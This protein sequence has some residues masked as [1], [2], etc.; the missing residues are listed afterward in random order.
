LSETD[1]DDVVSVDEIEGHYSDNENTE[2]EFDF[3]NLREKNDL[4]IELGSESISPNVKKQVA[5]LEALVDVLQTENRRLRSDRGHTQKT[6]YQKTALSLA[7]VG[8]VAV[9][10]GIVFPDV[11]S[12]LFATGTIGVIG[13]VMTWHLRPAKTVPIELCEGIYQSASMTLTDIRTDLGLEAVAMY[14]SFGNR[15]RGVIP[16]NRDSTVPDDLAHA[17]PTDHKGSKY[18]TFTPSGLSLVHEIEKIRITDKPQDFVTTVEAVAEGIVEHLEVADKV[19]IS[20]ESENSDLRISV[21]DPAFGPLTDIDHPVVSTL[22][23]AAVQSC[24]EPIIIETIDRETVI[25]KQVSN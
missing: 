22:A 3:V 5:E 19:A 15:V 1:P 25:L 13:S 12:V 9:I 23:C 17:F 6:S 4:S 16:P 10:G 11:R 21:D 24:D 2:S 8:L 20:Q 14:V 18:L 7:A